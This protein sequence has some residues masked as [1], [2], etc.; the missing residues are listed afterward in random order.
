LINNDIV[1]S[2]TWGNQSTLGFTTTAGMNHTYSREQTVTANAEDLIPGTE[3]VRGAVQSTSQNRCETATL[4]FFGQQQVA[5]NDQLFLTGALRWDASSTFGPDERWQL[6]PKLSGSYVLSASDW[7]QNSRISNLMNEFRLRGA[8]GY[9]GNQPP[10]GSAYAR[11]PRLVH[12]RRG[13]AWGA[14]RQAVRIVRAVRVRLVPERGHQRPDERVPAARRARLRWQPA[15]SRFRVRALPA[16]R[17]RREH[18]PVRP[19]A[20]GQPGQP[21]PEAGAPARVRG[22]LRCRLRQQ[23]HRRGVLVLRPVR[24]GPAAH[25][26]V[27]ADH[28]LLVDAVQRR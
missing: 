26:A 19:R 15:A 25:A 21:Q 23:P 12:V 2:Y 20:P 28:H 22:R 10:V 9:A 3:L 27:P 17:P 6:Y 7:H 11:T 24:E 8:L 4:G 14:E 16:L 5:W 13:G 18:N 1:A